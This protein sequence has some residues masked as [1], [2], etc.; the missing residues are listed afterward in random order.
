MS[1]DRSHA[2]IKPIAAASRF[3]FNMVKGMGMNDRSSCPQTTVQSG[4]IRDHLRWL[5]GS[6]TK[7]ADF[8]M[9]WWLDNIVARD[10]PGT[11]NRILA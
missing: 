7:A 2:V 1:A 10:H 9:G 11:G 4:K 8:R 3:P 5:S 6:Y